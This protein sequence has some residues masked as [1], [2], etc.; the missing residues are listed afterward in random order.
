M[1]SVLTSCENVPCGPG[2]P[3]AAGEDL[4]LVVTIESKENA[5]QGNHDAVS[6]RVPTD[7]PGTRATNVLQNT[8]PFSML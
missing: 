5:A 1:A 2:R 7:R 4:P 8:H 6:L 3:K